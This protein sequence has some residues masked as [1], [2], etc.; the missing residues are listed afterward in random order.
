MMRG[1]K[2]QQ[3]REAYSRFISTW[4]DKLDTAYLRLIYSMI[5]DYIEKSRKEA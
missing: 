3:D 5:K 1:N 2:E 4:L